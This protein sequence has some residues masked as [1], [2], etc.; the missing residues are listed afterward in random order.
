MH[1][2]VTTDKYH[3]D[4]FE[5]QNELLNEIL[6]DFLACCVAGNKISYN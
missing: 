6:I 3:N 1:K 5:S 2:L 4:K